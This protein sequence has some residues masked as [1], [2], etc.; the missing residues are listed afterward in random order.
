MLFVPSVV[1]GLAVLFTLMCNVW[2]CI[3]LIAA[4]TTLH[5]NYECY[6]L[7]FINFKVL[8]K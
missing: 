2:F 1:S 7:Y 4:I 5:L 6:M 3:I 8:N